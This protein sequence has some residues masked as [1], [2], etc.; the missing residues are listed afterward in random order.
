MLLAELGRYLGM[1]GVPHTRLQ[2]AVCTEYAQPVSTL[3]ISATAHG[4]GHKQA[5]SSFTEPGFFFFLIFY[6]RSMHDIIWFLG[7]KRA[8]R[9]CDKAFVNV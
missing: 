6:F 1:Y 4:N 7:E 8:R 9:R 3:A 2:S 5:S